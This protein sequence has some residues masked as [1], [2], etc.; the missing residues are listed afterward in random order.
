MLYRIGRYIL[1]AK[2]RE[3]E[4]VFVVRKGNLA[5]VQGRVGVDGGSNPKRD[6]GPSQPNERTGVNVGAGVQGGSPDDL[7]EVYILNPDGSLQ[8]PMWRH[9][10][11]DGLD[12]PEMPLFA[13]FKKAIDTASRQAAS[14]P[15]TP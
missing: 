14:K 12:P 8:G 15:A 7:L 1:T 10:V 5:S 3:A 9:Y 4:L 6:K 13:Q 2:R 11:K